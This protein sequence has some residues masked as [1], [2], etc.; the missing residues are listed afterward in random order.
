MKVRVDP[1]ACV[2]HGRCYVLAPDLFGEDE[3]GHC[4]IE[5]EAVPPGLEDAARTA[6]DNC[7]EGALALI[8]AS[9]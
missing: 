6:V 5:R 9:A 1:D 7:P 8:D 2:G 3:N 4:V